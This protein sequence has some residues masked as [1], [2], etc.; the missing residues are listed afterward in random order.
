VEESLRI[1]P[2]EGAVMAGTT[3]TDPDDNG[4]LSPILIDR[5]SLAVLFCVLFVT[6]IF[7]SDK[8]PMQ[9]WDES[10][11]ANNALE[12]AR[13]GH[14]LIPTYAGFPDHWNTKPPLLIWLI[15]GLLR[16]GLPPLW[17]LRTPSIIA[18]AATLGLIWGVLRY[19]LRDRLAA[20]LGGALLLS[21][22]LYLGPH[23]ARTGDYDALESLFMLG[24]VLCIW[25]ACDAPTRPEWIWGAGVCV[26]AAV[27]TKGIAGVLPL[28]GCAAF[29]LL[30]PK[31]AGAL[32]KRWPT[33]VATIGAL[34]LCLE[35]YATRELY[36]PGYIHAVTQNELGGRLL[37]VN[38]GH[39]EKSFYYFVILLVGFAPGTLFLPFAAMPIRGKDM[40]RRDLA[41][42]TLLSSAAL[43]LVLSYSRTK[44]VWYATPAVPLLSICAAIGI[45][46]A[47]GWVRRT[48]PR[49]AI[50]ALAAAAIPCAAGIG[51][52]TGQGRALLHL[53]H[54]PH[55]PR[56]DYG[57]FL[58]EL[59]RAGL[60]APT[61]VMDPAV[62]KDG[63]PPG[64]DPIARFYQTLYKDRWR[65]FLPPPGAA[66]P[67]GLRVVTCYREELAWLRSRYAVRVDYRDEDCVLARAERRAIVPVQASAHIRL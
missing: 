67:S 53:A 19:G 12:M 55:D 65:I 64:Y 31:K 24:Y 8:M 14:W 29:V 56:T 43:L 49:L 54:A 45:S 42:L 57:H 39:V 33:W 21:S 16:L 3:K 1:N 38:E 30:Q 44:I 11:N 5:I 18:A 17:A 23:A 27:M 51:L 20:T 15:A 46:D 13:S 6:L 63:S 26:V 7:N 36:D 37:V 4:Q 2:L 61:I 48:R 34:A 35:Y 10:R 28:P 32:L 59:Q 25:R 9:L 66:L 47:V 22:L 41:L 40:R 60:T 58:G 52:T 62:L 50:W